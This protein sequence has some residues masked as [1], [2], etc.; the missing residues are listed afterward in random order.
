[1]AKSDDIAGL[2]CFVLLVALVAGGV[3]AFSNF[4]WTNS[5]WYCVR[6]G[7]GFS[8]VQTA[9]RPIDCDFMSAPLGYK[10]CSYN[11]HVKVYDA[12][13]LLVA[14]EDAPKYGNDPKTGKPIFS[15]DGG[16][17]WQWLPGPIPNLKPKSV[18]MYWVKE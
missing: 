2:G 8:D 10:G 15:N 13:G 5:I 9:A 1:M 16:K 14:G 7:V 17:T 6:Y 11:A 3:L 4:G 12:D 18:I